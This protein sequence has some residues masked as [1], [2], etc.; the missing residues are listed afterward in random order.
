MG[1]WTL[2]VILHGIPNNPLRLADDEDVLQTRVEAVSS[3]VLPTFFGGF[4]SRV[5]DASCGILR[6]CHVS[7][8]FRDHKAWALV[9]VLETHWSLT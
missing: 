9:W 8:D 6:L 5:W 2:R 7:Y 1:T 3:R 4:L